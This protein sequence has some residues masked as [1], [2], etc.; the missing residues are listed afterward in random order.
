M[1]RQNELASCPLDPIHK[2]KRSSLHY[3]LSR[4]KAQIGAENIEECP[5]NSA[6][7]W[8]KG[9]KD[10]NSHIEECPDK[11]SIHIGINPLSSPTPCDTQREN[12][13]DWNDDEN[14]AA[15]ASELVAPREIQLGRNEYS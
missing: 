4:C 1:D 9:K 15:A 7:I 5:Y 13:T 2:V 8:V 12:P 14:W 3:H 10:V 6:H 11:K